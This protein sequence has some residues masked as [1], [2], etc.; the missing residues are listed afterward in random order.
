MRSWR[1]ASDD[2]GTIALMSVLAR[3]NAAVAV[4]DAW[5]LG[6]FQCQTACVASL[7]VKAAFDVAKASVVCKI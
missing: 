5:V 4:R 6:F 3:W 2:F 7:D 1:T